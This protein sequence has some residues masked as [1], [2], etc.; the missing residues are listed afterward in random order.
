MVRVWR[1]WLAC[2]LALCAP[3]AAKEQAPLVLAKGTRVGVINLLR[4]EVVHFHSAKAI[5]DRAL[6]TELVGWPLDT[7]LVNALKQRA[8]QIGLVLV[9]LPPGN[10][11]EHAREDCFLNNGF[12]KTL[13]KDCVAPFEHLLTNA[14][15]EAVIVLAPGLNN[16]T[17]AGSARRKELP[18]ELRG[19][20][21]V[22]GVAAAEDGKPD[23]FS[24]SDLMLVAMSGEG[25]ELR[26]HDWGG[27]Y[28]MEWTSFAAP[29]PKVVPIDD[30][31]QL[32]PL[33]ESILQ[34]QGERLLSQVQV[35]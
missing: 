23:L 33:F 21:Y 25:P 17:H 2:L 35:Q 15:L 10:E 29:D 20:G 11:L 12:N 1:G 19:W 8:A 16:G 18:D 30:Y 22:T 7:M 5:K 4:P 9:P 27:N 13:P 3:L 32:E 26:A 31:D 14:G 24:M 28:S 34:R 6:K